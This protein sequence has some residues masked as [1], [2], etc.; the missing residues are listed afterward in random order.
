MRVNLLRSLE[1]GLKYFDRK[2]KLK[3]YFTELKIYTDAGVYFGLNVQK[4][5][6]SCV[7][8]HNHVT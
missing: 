3:C 2:Y 8:E 6:G 5:T 4:G 7:G 1:L